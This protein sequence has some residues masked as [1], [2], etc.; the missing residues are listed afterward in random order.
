MNER[1]SSLAAWL[2]GLLGILVIAAGCGKNASS[3]SHKGE[4]EADEEQEVTVGDLTIDQVMQA[5]CPHGL[6]IECAECR[7]EVG[8]VK[9]DPTLLKQGDGSSTGLVK[10]IQVAKS[11]M[12]TAVN[13][14]GEIGMNDNAAVHVSPRIAGI[15][16]AV[17][18]D[19]G[20]EVKKD[21]VLFTVDS[22]ELGQ[23]LSDHEKNIALA[24]LS[25]KTFQREKSLY[26]QKVAA[27]SDM[28]EAQMRFEEYQTARKASEQRLHVLGLS[29]SDIAALSLTN[30]GSLSGAL[31]VRAPMSGTLIEKHAVVGELVEPGKDVMVLADLNTVWMWGGVYERDLGLLLK[32]NLGRRNSRGDH[33]PRLP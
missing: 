22:V 6:T 25:G 5:K 30:H 28:I 18:V 13:I 9:V 33:R 23:A 26:E 7:Y 19:I 8:V 27:E 12:V 10:T 14:T 2:C 29:E 4:A 1:K 21:D 32:R 20:A 17:N 24:E 3:E 15:I 16:R 31:A 11:K